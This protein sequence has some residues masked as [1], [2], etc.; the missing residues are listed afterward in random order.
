MR[1]GGDKHSRMQLV[2][3]IINA[4]FQT[5]MQVIHSNAPFNA[6]LHAR[7]RWWSVIRS[8]MHLW[9]SR[10]RL[11]HNSACTLCCMQQ[12]AARRSPQEMRCVLLYA[13]AM[14]YIH[15]L[16]AHI[17][18]STQLRKSTVKLACVDCTYLSVRLMR[19]RQIYTH[20]YSRLSLNLLIV[21]KAVSLFSSVTT[22]SLISYSGGGQSNNV[23]L[24]ACEHVQFKV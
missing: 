17:L 22:P 21:S 24:M 14:T 2:S 4:L 12:K 18:W 15:F 6:W 19:M 9:T 20:D 13:A 8:C 7:W 23:K 1:G 10:R 5:T 16:H 11:T 3:P